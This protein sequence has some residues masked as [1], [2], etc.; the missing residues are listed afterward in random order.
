M[1][2]TSRCRKLTKFSLTT[3]II[4][5]SA[6]PPISP[7]APSNTI[8]QTAVLL[9]SCGITSNP[10]VLIPSSAIPSTSKFPNT[11][12]PTA[13]NK[14]AADGSPCDTR[15][16]WAASTMFRPT[17]PDDSVMVPG[18]VECKPMEL[19][20][21]LRIF[22][23]ADMSTAAEPITTNLAGGCQKSQQYTLQS[24]KRIDLPQREN[25]Y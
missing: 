24:K 4:S 13:D 11:S 23:C 10:S 18:D 5:M 17:P 9:S 22:D 2:R 20:L 14:T 21:S 16:R 7:P 1:T 25:F 12:L 6:T 3:F 15:T 8:L 19:T